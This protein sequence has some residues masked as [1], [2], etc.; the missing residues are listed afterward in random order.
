MNLFYLFIYYEGMNRTGS[1]DY[2]AWQ[3]FPLSCI[4]IIGNYYSKIGWVSSFLCFF[5]LFYEITLRNVVKKEMIRVQP[6]SE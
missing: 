1:R 5:I 4:K 6:N 3:W 2:E